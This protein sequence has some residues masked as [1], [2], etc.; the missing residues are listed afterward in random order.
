M[1]NWNRLL[2]I[3][4]GVVSAVSETVLDQ[5][6]VFDC[7]LLKFLVQIHGKAK[8]AF[9]FL[10]VF[11]RLAGTVK[12]LRQKRH[13][14]VQT[15]LEAD[16]DP[17]VNKRGHVP[18]GTQSAGQKKGKPIEFLSLFVLRLDDGNAY[19]KVVPNLIV[20]PGKGRLGNALQ[21]AK[22]NR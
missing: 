21:R 17:L 19:L 12:I 15:I 5:I 6:T 14:I 16:P 10:S 2:A 3:T 4:R 1:N 22:K 11:E 18:P 13:V 9:V 8:P 20:G 7:N